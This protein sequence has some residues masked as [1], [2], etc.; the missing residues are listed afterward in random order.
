MVFYT[1]KPLLKHDPDK[2]NQKKFSSSS[3]SCSPQKR[4]C[5]R[6]S[7]FL[8]HLESV[9]LSELLGAVAKNQ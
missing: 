5:D 1:L 3:L 8:H 6:Q 7:L 2:K 4:P 9:Q